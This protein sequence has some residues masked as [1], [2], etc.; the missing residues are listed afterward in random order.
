MKS[1]EFIARI[2]NLNSQIEA[3]LSLDYDMYYA[4][5]NFSIN[6]SH[7][8]EKLKEMKDRNNFLQGLIYLFPL[9]RVLLN[10]FIEAFPQEIAKIPSDVILSIFYDNLSDFA[11]IKDEDLL[12]NKIKEL[13][14]Q[15]KKI[16][17]EI[18]QLNGSYNKLND[19]FNK[20]NKELEKLKSDYEKIKE[21]YEDTIKVINEL[22]PESNRL[23]EEIKII[24]DNASLHLKKDE[25]ENKLNKAKEILD[26]IKRKYFPTDK[27]EEE[28]NKI[29]KI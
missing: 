6:F 4:I 23:R 29:N 20:K 1:D 15:L 3:E 25:I 21:K 12:K 10:R 22:L 14:E 16:T 27:A 28:L 11:K 5:K 18:I 19:E 17:P 2:A 26:E 8:I 24:E 13:E 9:T 7:L